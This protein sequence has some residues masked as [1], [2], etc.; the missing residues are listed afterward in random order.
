M[1]PPLQRKW[2]LPYRVSRKTT[3]CS[4]FWAKEFSFCLSL[5]MFSL[6]FSECLGGMGLTWLLFQF[7]KIKYFVESWCGTCVVSY[8]KIINSENKWYKHL[9]A[10]I[11]WSKYYV[12]KYWANIISSLRI[13]RWV[14]CKKHASV[15]WTLD[16]ALFGLEWIILRCIDVFIT[17]RRL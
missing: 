16:F 15:W 6:T 12:T 13:P 5:L 17:K 3:H 2:L 8:C 4:T 9:E 1:G 10:N 7:W 14:V 11:V